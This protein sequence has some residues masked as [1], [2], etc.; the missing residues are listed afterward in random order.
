[1]IEQ[2]K[3]NDP[4]FEQGERVMQEML[5]AHKEGESGRAS[6]LKNAYS[7]LLKKYERRRKSIQPQIDSARTCRFSLQKQYWKILQT[8]WKVRN[9]SILNV[10]KAYDKL[11]ENANSKELHSDFESAREIFHSL[12][13]ICDGLKARSPSS[14]GDPIQLSEAWNPILSE[15]KTIAERHVDL[16]I[17]VKDLANQLT[18][19]EETKPRTGM[20]FQDQKRNEKR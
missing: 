8:S 13:E 12:N 2:A 17:Q 15:Y 19:T 14:S 11:P 10:L 4:V 18:S 16:W 6:E 1:Q 3:K 5:K 7:D 9:D 20:A